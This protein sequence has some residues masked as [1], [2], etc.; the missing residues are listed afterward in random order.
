MKRSTALVVRI[1]VTAASQLH[2]IEFICSMERESDERDRDGHRILT[3]GWRTFSVFSRNEI[4][5]RQLRV[6][7]LTKNVYKRVRKNEE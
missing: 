4:A 6:I 7:D 1:I 2:V 3:S 5:A